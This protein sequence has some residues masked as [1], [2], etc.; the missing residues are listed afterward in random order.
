MAMAG[1]TTPTVVA[2][3]ATIATGATEQDIHQ[4]SDRL[5]LEAPSFDIGAG[6]TASI[7]L[8]AD[9]DLSIAVER[10]VNSNQITTINRA[11][12][13]PTAASSSSTPTAASSARVAMSPLRTSSSP[14]PTLPMTNS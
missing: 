9:L 14:R 6:Y 5:I 8:S 12:C 7:T 3:S 11:T 2:G 1:Q 4:S 10:V 13:L